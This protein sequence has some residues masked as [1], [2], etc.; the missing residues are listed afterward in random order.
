MK[1]KLLILLTALMITSCQRNYSGCV[2]IAEDEEGRAVIIKTESG[3]S[4]T[5]YTSYPA[6]AISKTYNVGDTIK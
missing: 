1:H 6:N 4:L 3:Q 5:L 2:V